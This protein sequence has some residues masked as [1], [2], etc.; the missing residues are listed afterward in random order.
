MIKNNT[1]GLTLVEVVVSVA[2]VSVIS[3]ITLGLVTSAMS[4]K[5]RGDALMRDQ[6][7]M[8]QALL[9]ITVEIRKTPNGTPVENRY[10]LDA[11]GMIKRTDDS[12]V[13]KNI[14]DFRIT[15]ANKKAT[16]YIKSI[17]GQEAKTVVHLRTAVET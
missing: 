11:N 5:N 9:T 16:I 4:A 15:V 10:S 12:V 2:L 17:N 1:S 8:R 3:I 14:A 13:V 7:S 6:I